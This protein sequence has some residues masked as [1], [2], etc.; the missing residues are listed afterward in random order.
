[1]NKHLTITGITA[2]SALVFPAQVFATR[3]LTIEEAQKQMFADASFLPASIKLTNDDKAKIKAITG[4]T[5]SFSVIKGWK[6]TAGG[7]TV[8]FVYMDYVI[9]KHLLIDYALALNADGTVKQVEILEYRE[10]YGGEIRNAGW[11]KQFKG[12]KASSLLLLNSD[13]YNISGATLSCRHLTKGIKNLL[14][15]HEKFGKN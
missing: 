4:N 6:A 3:F 7:K 5:P 12:K 10:S 14:T 9:G 13:I 15:I 8:G 1:M 11:R 2:A